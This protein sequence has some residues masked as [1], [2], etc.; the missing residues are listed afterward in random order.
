[1]IAHPVEM[2]T[3]DGVIKGK[4]TRCIHCLKTKSDLAGEPMLLA[5]VITDFEPTH[6]ALTSHGLAIGGTAK[7]EGVHV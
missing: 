1:M 2:R 6:V 7:R 4:L 3:D 5:D